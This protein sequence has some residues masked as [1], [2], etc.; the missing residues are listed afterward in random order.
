[1]G[2]SII[3]ESHG[4]IFNLS[5]ATGVFPENWKTAR[6]SP[7]FESGEEIIVP[8]ADRSLY[9]LFVQDFLRH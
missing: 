9:S 4:K 6:V 1:M 3:A 5:I 7:I 8:I 2:I